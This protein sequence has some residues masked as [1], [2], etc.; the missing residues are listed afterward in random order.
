M[1]DKYV[2]GYTGSQVDSRLARPVSVAQG[3]TGQTSRYSA[4][5]VTNDTSVVSGHAI[6]IRHYPQLG[7]CFVRGYV[8]LSGTAVS[9]NTWFP[10]ATVTGDVVPSTENTTALS[11]N[12][13]GGGDA[14]IT[15]DGQIRCRVNTAWSGTSG[16]RDIYFSGWWQAT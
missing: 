7:M 9:A 3:G 11:V 8:R 16:T 13:Y 4:A 15:G 6:T 2:L 1:A 10:I 12:T 14:Q 5:T